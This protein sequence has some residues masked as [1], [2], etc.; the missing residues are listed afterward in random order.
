MIRIAL[1]FQSFFCHL[2]HSMRYHSISIANLKCYDI[3]LFK[4]CDFGIF[5][6][7]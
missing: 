1:S 3:I 2:C 6:K 4:I 5:Y 7:N